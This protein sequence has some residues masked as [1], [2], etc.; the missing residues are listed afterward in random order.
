M[1]VPIQN[2]YTQ[3]FH[4]FMTMLDLL[5]PKTIPW[6][7]YNVWCARLSDHFIT[8][9]W[10]SRSTQARQRNSRTLV[11]LNALGRMRGGGDIKKY[12]QFE[13]L[14]HMLFLQLMHFLQNRKYFLQWFKCIFYIWFIIKLPTVTVTYA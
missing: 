10:N 8:K 14:I 11:L 13:L 3:I 2:S 4:F 6:F 9:S 5:Y 7:C 12:Y 1:C